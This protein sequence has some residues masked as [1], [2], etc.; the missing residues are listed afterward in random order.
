MKWHVIKSSLVPLPSKRKN[1]ISFNQQCT[2]K[3]CL[4]NHSQQNEHKRAP[5]LVPISPPLPS[6]S[7]HQKSWVSAPMEA[8]HPWNITS[9]NG[10]GSSCTLYKE[11]RFPKNRRRYMGGRY[12][13]HVA[14]FKTLQPPP[15]PKQ[16]CTYMTKIEGD[17]RKLCYTVK[18]IQYSILQQRNTFWFYIHFCLEL[19]YFVT[20]HIFDL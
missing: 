8:K 18:D 5:S 20:K 13:N 19:I 7:M 4:L 11:S 2:L 10:P 6:I 15:P 14:H 3:N 16:N 9:G 17:Y 1:A 12:I